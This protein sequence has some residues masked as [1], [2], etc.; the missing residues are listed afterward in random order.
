VRAV[1]E[2]SNIKV[3]LTPEEPDFYF[4]RLSEFYAAESAYLA[5]AA[6]LSKIDLQP[7]RERLNAAEQ[8]VEEA[9]S[10]VLSIEQAERL[11]SALYGAITK[12]KVEAGRYSYADV[13]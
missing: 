8:D 9:L 4:A 13:D 3:Y 12:A 1:A 11:F 10:E 2:G 5:H 6:D 7:Y